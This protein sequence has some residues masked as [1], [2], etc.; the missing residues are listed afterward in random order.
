MEDTRKYVNFQNF[1]ILKAKGFA[2]NLLST[3]LSSRSETNIQL[4]IVLIKMF[5]KLVE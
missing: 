5:C 4:Q 2:K 3:K 1:R